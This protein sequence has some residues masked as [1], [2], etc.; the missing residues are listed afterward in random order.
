MPPISIKTP[1]EIKIMTEG[2]RKLARVREVLAQTIKPGIT[3][4]EIERLANKLITEEKA[5]ASF[6]MVPGYHWATCINVN[7]VV[8][9]GIPGPQKL[10]S[11]DIVGIDVGIYWRG[12][13]TDTSVTVPVGHVNPGVQ[14]FL[15][16]GKT[17][18]REAISRA[19]PGQRVAD[20]SAAMQEAV[21]AAGFSAV[22]ALTGHGIGHALHEEP[23]IPCFS[24]GSYHKSPL[25]VS[26][27]VLA[28]E[29]MYNQGTSE[30][31]YQNDDGWTIA[32]ADGKISGLFEETVAVTAR[33]PVVLTTVK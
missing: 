22:R 4:L 18:L 30:V 6:K 23:Q 10:K 11:G 17:G 13:H 20:L 9:H 8:V 14:R 21:E 26:G 1:A 25:L 19:R 2:G 7:D 32:T 33:G 15:E 27:M 29:I 3:T 31:M 28:I 24:L 12:W 5:T 16:V